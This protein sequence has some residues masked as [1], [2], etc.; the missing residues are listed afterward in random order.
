M[1]KKRPL[2]REATPVRDA[3]LVVIASEDKYAVK[4]YFDFFESTK[5]QFR[6]LE[7]SDGK[8]A[9]EYVHER[10]SEYIR[11]FEIGEGDTLWVVCDC[12]HWVQ[13]GHIQNPTHV[14]QECR[15][16]H[17]EVALSNPC[18]DL[19]LLLHFADFPEEEKLTCDEVATQLRTAVGG[20]DKKKVYNLAIDDE[21][22]SSAVKRARDNP[23]PRMG[24]PIRPQTERLSRNSRRS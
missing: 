7:T 4:Q 23:R 13:P 24:I 12:D 11:E 6:V 8:S 9:P 14:I 16:K 2:D 1:R 20:Y 10:I 3:S 17:I 21:K 19:W 18:F 5:I 15:K 22:V